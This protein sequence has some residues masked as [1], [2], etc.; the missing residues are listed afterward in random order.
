VFLVV[1]SRC[2]TFNK[3]CERLC[4]QVLLRLLQDCA[5][6]F[7]QLISKISGNSASIPFVALLIRQCQPRGEQLVRSVPF[8]YAAPSER[9]AKKKIGTPNLQTDDPNAGATLGASLE[10]LNA[11]HHYYQ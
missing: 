11:I 9:S 6:A 2:K 8:Q 10:K 7:S 3:F 1:G 5:K 4:P